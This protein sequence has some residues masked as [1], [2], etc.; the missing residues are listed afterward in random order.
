MHPW[1]ALL[2]AGV[3]LD[4]NL[5]PTQEEGWFG[6]RTVVLNLAVYYIRA[7]WESS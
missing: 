1:P 4:S 3:G 2:A 6:Y 7:T 5:P